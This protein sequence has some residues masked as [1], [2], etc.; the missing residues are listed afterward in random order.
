MPLFTQTLRGSEDWGKVF[1]EA[2][3]WQPLIEAIYQREGLAKEV[4]LKDI[5]LLT[6]GTNAVFR[7]GNTVVKIMAPE[8]TGMQ[9]AI[10]GSSEYMAHM[11]AESLGVPVPAMRAAGTM[12]DSYTFEYIVCEFVPGQELGR[13]LPTWS[14]EEQD[15]A[16]THLKAMVRSL[17]QGEQ[18]TQGLE[19]LIERALTNARWLQFKPA[20]RSEVFRRVR[21]AS[22]KML[23][24]VH[25]DM[26]GENV[27]YRTEG[28]AYAANAESPLCLLD[29]GDS[30]IAP[31][32]YE[33]A[34]LVF[35]LFDM[36]ARLTKTFFRFPNGACFL[37]VLLPAVLLHD[38]GADYLAKAAQ[39]FL[40]KSPEEVDS[41]RE[42]EAMLLQHIY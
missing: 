10:F 5:G 26:T 2:A 9:D 1:H 35:E 18:Y 33:Y 40:H 19:P 41:V 3:Y 32:E 31:P 28:A 42:L 34:A 36:D 17:Q 37:R 12:H 8:E 38:F 15:V 22:A 30:C 4:A 39:R 21:G 23:M 20:V 29:F 24:R 16:L 14:H 13:L 7:V 6:P 25:G 11:E 27:L